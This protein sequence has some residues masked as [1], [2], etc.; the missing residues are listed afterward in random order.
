MKKFVILF[1]IITITLFATNKQWFNE[2]YDN[3]PTSFVVQD[4]SNTMNKLLLKNEGKI[5]IDNYAYLGAVTYMIYPPALRAVIIVDMDKYYDDIIKIVRSKGMPIKNTKNKDIKNMIEDYKKMAKEKAIV[6][7]CTQ[8]E[9][10]Y[11]LERGISYSYEMRL[12]GYSTFSYDI[13]IEDCSDDKAKII[14]GKRKIFKDI[15]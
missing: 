6:G 11:M 1:S 3:K 5:N 8:E 12:G 9:K 2:K 13:G 7:A 14:S 10:R 15:D 4:L